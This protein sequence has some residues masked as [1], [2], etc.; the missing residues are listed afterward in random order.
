MIPCPK[1]SSVAMVKKERILGS[2][3]R[4]PR[5]DQID[6][7]S[8]AGVLVLDGTGTAGDVLSI[9]IVSGLSVVGSANLKD[10]C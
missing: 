4:M 5:R 7:D 1:P 8:A 3:K 9:V 10:F 6:A 2:R